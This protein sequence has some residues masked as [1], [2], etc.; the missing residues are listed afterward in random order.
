MKKLVVGNFKGGVGKT[1]VAVNLAVALA[2]LLDRRVLLVDTDPS[3]GVTA[4]FRI[5]PELTLYHILMDGFDPEQVM[6][7]VEDSG[8][9]YVVASSRATQA[10]E[11]QIASRIGRERVLEEAMASVSDFDYV[12]LDTQP[13]MSVIAQNAF[14]YARQ[15]LVPVS[16]DPMSLLGLASA[17]GLA[18]DVRKKMRVKMSILGLVPTFFDARLLVARAV[19]ETLDTKYGEIPVLP[20][21]RSDT[22]VRK[23]TA[24]R[25]PVL[26]FDKRTRAA[27][28]FLEL[29]AEVDR[30]CHPSGKGASS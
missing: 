3:A 2:K 30:R 19:M 18:E 16:M 11:F 22:N 27:E 25:A 29:A 17:L 1:T 28:D 21:I 5:Q 7:P 12:I 13:S 8:R 14:V 4:H 6:L 26:Q 9:L 20:P 10:A 15:L 23:A 24:S